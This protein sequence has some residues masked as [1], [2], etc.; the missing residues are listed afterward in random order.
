MKDRWGS[1]QELKKGL[2]ESGRAVGPDRRK[3]W[4]REQYRSSDDADRRKRE[5]A[6]PAD[7]Q[8]IGMVKLVGQARCTPDVVCGWC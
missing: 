6:G 8:H 5:G 7:D 3:S 4:K 2:D 1:L